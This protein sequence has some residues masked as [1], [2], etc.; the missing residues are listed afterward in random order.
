MIFSSNLFLFIFLPLTLIIYHLCNNNIRNV[1]LLIASLIFYAWGEPKYVFLMIISIML[2]YLIGIIIEECKKVVLRKL[3]ITSGIVLN[4]GLLFYFKYYEFFIDNLNLVFNFSIPVKSIILPIGISFYT[5]QTLSYIVDVYR[6]IVKAQ[7]SIINLGL[8]ISLF[9]QLIAGPI[10]RYIDIEQQICSRELNIDKMYKG[11][12]KFMLGFI[13]K[14][15]IADQVAV[16]ANLAFSDN[17]L[18]GPMAWIGIISYTIQIYFDF[19][20]YSDMAIGLGRLFGFEFI[21]NFNYPYISKSIKEFWRRWH[22]SLSTWFKDYVYIPLGGSRCS[23]FKA[24]RNL[25]IVF[26]LTGVW[27]GA[28]WNFIAWGL[29]YAVFLVIERMWLGQVL[30]RKSTLIART[31]TLIVIM[32]GWIL[33]RANDL[34]H[35]IYYIKRL[36][37]FPSGSLKTLILNITFEQILLIAIG[38]IFSFP[39]YNWFFKKTYN[40]IIYDITVITLF[41]VS[42]LYMV[43][44]GFSPFLYFRF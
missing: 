41:I 5:F 21:E 34:T 32:F 36:F 19:S 27:H 14:V 3:I 13:K 24:Y 15:L 23:K 39:I 18:T 12:I 17:N 35:S 2:N 30:E 1:F 40:R 25:V 28:S 43:G 38:I 6:G 16:V 10:V 29:Y 33:F 26:L 11:S 44:S 4:L 8:Y 22:I 42:I 31:Y 7:R 9:P 37:Y 20:G